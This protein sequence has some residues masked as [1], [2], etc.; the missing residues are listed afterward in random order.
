MSA[1]ATRR[2]VHGAPRV[3]RNGIGRP[4]LL[5]RLDPAMPL[6]VVRAP[7]GSGKSLL[8]AQWCHALDAPGVWVGL[9]GEAG[10]RESVWQAVASRLVDAGLARP[11][12]LLARA[13]ELLVG[14]ADVRALLVRAFGQLGDPVLVVLDDY[15]AVDDEALHADV[16]A[17]VAAC[18]AV[19]VV[20]TTRTSSPLEAAEVAVGVDRTVLG[21][22]D[23]AFTLDETRALLARHGVEES[24]AAE[25]HRA[26]GGNPL[27]MRALL[28]QGVDAA[29]SAGSPSPG[30]LAR[31]V[32]LSL[33]ARADPAL[34]RL[35][36]RT[37]LP[38]AF[39]LDLACLLV[40]DGDGADTARRLD[41]LEALGVVTR[42]DGPGGDVYRYHPVVRD[43]LAEEAGARLGRDLARL[44]T[45]VARWSL[46]H[47]EPLTALRHAVRGG[48]LRLASDVLIGSWNRLITNAEMYRAVAQVPVQ[49]VARHPVLAM[50]RAIAANADPDRRLRALELLGMAVASARVVGPRTAGAE[51]ATVAT[52]EAVALRLSGLSDQGLAAARRALAVL[53][54]ADADELETLRDQAGHLRVQN[55]IT[56]ARAGHLADAREALTVNLADRA[57]LPS[58]TE[59]TTLSALAGITALLGEMPAARRLAAEVAQ[60]PWPDEARDGYS[61]APY[62]VAGLLEALERFDVGGAQQHL[63]V[64]AP[65]LPALEYRPLFV[66]LQAWVHG[67]AGRAE[68]GLQAL[69][70]YAVE[71]RGHRRSSPPDTLVL[72]CVTALLQL[73]RGRA[74]AAEQALRG[75][76][77]RR[78]LVAVVRA[79]VALVTG[80]PEKVAVT[81]ARAGVPEAVPPR[82]AVAGHLLVA[83]AAQRLGDPAAVTVALERMAALMADQGLRTHL[84][85]V[86]RADLHDLRAH[87]EGHGLALAA[88]HLRHLGDVPDVVPVRVSRIVLT[89]RESVI[90]HALLDGSSLT[91]VAEELVVSPNT[92]KSQVK[93]LYR[94]LGVT[95]R[96]DAVLAAYREGVLAPP[97][98]AL[99][100]GE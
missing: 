88:E 50:A 2:G 96:E 55:A 32:V 14:V 44:H 47:A 3:P 75:L 87:A 22:D 19:S 40:G 29:A 69:D 12:S 56:L 28:L 37:S 41:D 46:H 76:S 64:L 82:A 8:V 89:A 74:G 9:G 81:L 78:P 79:A 94:K 98:G 35:V 13:G 66:A 30:S 24:R 52:V 84:V 48:D 77:A 20:V 51:R 100:R 92:V 57:H 6:T 60:G 62:H 99:R 10:T 15:H 45:L 36:L 25:V 68:L 38:E 18:P 85:L 71:D 97:D 42:S 17:V 83:A 23:L 21:P 54:A 43:V 7:A 39:D 5:A 27:L 93:S 63:D 95:S 59:M 31:D 33:V 67:L 26:C 86:P 70:R 1:T 58:L 91:R 49:K 72:W 4:R 34:R 90:L 80:E 53:A 73:S 16:L 65:H 61:G 11:D